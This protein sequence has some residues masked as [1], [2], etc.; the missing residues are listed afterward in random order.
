MSDRLVA[1]APP[2]KKIEQLT[3]Q[4]GRFDRLVRREIVKAKARVLPV[5]KKRLR[6]PQSALRGACN[7]RG[8]SPQRF[9]VCAGRRVYRGLFSWRRFSQFSWLYPCQTIPIF[10]ANFFSVA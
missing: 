1:S 8:G 9:T 2:A 3:N 5:D 6:T 10:F 4:R 7:R